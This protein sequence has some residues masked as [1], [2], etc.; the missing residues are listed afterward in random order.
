MSEYKQ[1]VATVREPLQAPTMRGQVGVP[2]ALAATGAVSGATLVALIASDAHAEQPFRWFVYAF[3][4]LFIALFWF[5]CRAS[6]RTLWRE[7]IRRGVDLDQDGSVGPPGHPFAVNARQRNLQQEQQATEDLYFQRLEWF[8]NTCH[9]RLGRGR[10]IAEKDMTQLTMPDGHKLTME[11]YDQFR[12]M[13]IRLRYA[14]WRNA[15]RHKTGWQL[16]PG[17]SAAE[18]MRQARVRHE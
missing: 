3:I 9:Q 8:V 16:V 14:E 18:I 11:L 2:L 1:Q 4:V 13:L 12:D 10:G 5:A 6:H 7:E 15:F 17:L